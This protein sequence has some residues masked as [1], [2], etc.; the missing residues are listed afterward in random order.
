M[1][2]LRWVRCEKRL[3]CFEGAEQKYQKK[4]HC[5]NKPDSDSLLVIVVVE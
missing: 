1:F 2:R 4:N 5:K 3:E